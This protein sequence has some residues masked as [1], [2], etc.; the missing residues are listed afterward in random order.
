MDQRVYLDY[1]SATPLD[2]RVREAMLPYLGE[3]FGN[4]SSLHETGMVAKNALEEARGK[5]ANLIHA[6]PEEVI[7]TSSGSEANNFAILGLA[8]AQREGQTSRYLSRRPF[9]GPAPGQVP[10]RGGLGGQPGSGGPL[11][12]SGPNGR[13][14]G[15]PEGYRAHLHPARQQRGGNDPAGL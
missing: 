5:V 3:G 10:G 11:W 14:E 4:P 1:A 13:G 9:L 15:H 2:P 6:L 8:R 12:T 7:F